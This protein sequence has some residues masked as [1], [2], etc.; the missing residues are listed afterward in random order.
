MGSIPQLPHKRV[1]KAFE[2]AGFVVKREGKH[3]TMAKG[4]SIITIPRNN[5][6]NTHTLK[7]IILSAGLTIDDF[8]K[9]I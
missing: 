4:I 1:V 8:K 9:L 3:I 6:V 2:K 7:S 5:P